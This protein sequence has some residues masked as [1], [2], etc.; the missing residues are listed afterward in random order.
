MSET[1][2]RMM[3][4]VMTKLSVVGIHACGDA[5]TW[6]WYEYTTSAQ[7]AATV[8]VQVYRMKWAGKSARPQAIPRRCA[9]GRQPPGERRHPASLDAPMTK[10]SSMLR[11]KRSF[12]SRE[13]VQKERPVSAL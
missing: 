11:R 8:V 2:K 6:T 1:K 9:D 3:P 4:K 5:V 7:R 13:A 10:R 12:I